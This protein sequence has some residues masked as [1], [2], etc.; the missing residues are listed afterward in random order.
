MFG[1][2]K[3]T[4]LEK[5][6]YLDF[7]NNYCATCKTI[8]KLYGHLERVSLNYDVV[9]LNELLAALDNKEKNI[10]SITARDCW[11]L[12]KNDNT[13]P[14]YLTYT[15]SINVLLRQYKIMDNVLDSRSENNVWKL[16]QYF[17]NSNFAKARNI[18]TNYNLPIRLIDNRIHEQFKREKKKIKFDN[19]Q[20]TF[21]YYSDSTGEIT[22]IVFG[23]GVPD[24]YNKKIRLLFTKIGYNFGRIVYLIDGIEDYDRDVKYGQFNYLLIHDDHNKSELVQ[25]VAKYILDCLKIIKDCIND[26]PIDDIKK[27]VFVNRLYVNVSAKI[28][29]P[30][31]RNLNHCDNA[32]LS[33]KE[34]YNYALMAAKNRW[35]ITDRAKLKYPAFVILA[36]FFII[37]FLFFPQLIRNA[38]DSVNNANCC[39]DCGGWCCDGCFA[40]WCGSGR[41]G[42][43]SGHF[44]TE[45]CD[46]L[47]SIWPSCILL[48][49]LIGCCG[50]A[51]EGAKEAPKVIIKV[52]KA[53]SDGC[54]G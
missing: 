20:D 46:K 38:D 43:S 53:P 26:L 5:K 39:G 15:A 36:I 21:E 9:F 35:Q 24:H 11:K 8:G 44:A 2:L 32:N 41:T 16:L 31:Y 29:S 33:I 25:H 47:G 23:C 54:C 49:G 18:L 42:C 45:A 14:Y 19:Y 37:F 40:S 12:P 6:G 13:I 4:R 52:I 1:L 10:D 3:E 22:S 17:G 28:S 7:R 27:R 34:R 30:R 48:C 50:G 51:C